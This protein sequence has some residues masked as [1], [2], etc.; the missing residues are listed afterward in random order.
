MAASLEHDV[1]TVADAD[2]RDVASLLQRFGLELVVQDEADA[3]KGSYWGEPEAGIV[4]KTVYVR[5]DTPVHSALHEACH[6]VC[7]SGDRRAALDR[8]AGGDDLEESAVCYLQVVLA[9]WLP[10]CGRARLMRDMDAWG[11]SFRLGSTAEWF[12]RD[13][14]DAQKFLINHGLLTI[15]EAPTFRLRV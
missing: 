14:E 7:M 12:R 4:G 6:V 11:Y 15:L 5:G 9:D 1:L 13:A 2:V 8:D 10:A 3:I